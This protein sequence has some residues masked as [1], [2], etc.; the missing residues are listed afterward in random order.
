MKRLGRREWLLLLLF[1]LVLIV[2]GL[3][4]VRAVRRAVYWHE[5]RDEPIRSW[6]SVHY[7]A[8]SYRVPAPILY[9]SIGE[10]PIPR[11]RRPLI[12]I[13]RKQ[14]RSVDTVI[15]ELQLAILDFRKL[16][17]PPSSPLAPAEGA[18]R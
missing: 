9:Q 12:E 17:H 16:N 1:L 4:S 13:A 3:F 2:T 18:A 7:V 5:H 11:D 10:V 8:R 14:N 6:M 15:S